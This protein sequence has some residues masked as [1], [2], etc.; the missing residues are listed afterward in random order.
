MVS[1]LFD[2]IDDGETWFVSIV[3]VLA[4]GAWGL[5]AY[6][7]VRWAFGDGLYWAEKDHLEYPDVKEING[8]TYH[9]DPATVPSVEVQQRD[10]I[11]LSVGT[12]FGRLLAVVWAVVTAAGLFMIVMNAQA[13][14]RQRWPAWRQAAGQ[15]WQAYRAARATAPV[16][17]A[18]VPA[19]AQAWATAA[20]AAA[21]AVVA[22]FAWADRWDAALLTGVVF[23]L[24]LGTAVSLRGRSGEL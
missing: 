10:H 4:M 22:A 12:V 17:P 15:R 16:R 11:S 24:A 19:Q 21:G 7:A 6:C 8:A 9:L 1:G 23:A 5:G 20:A 14:V 13:L 18:Y 2:G 3:L